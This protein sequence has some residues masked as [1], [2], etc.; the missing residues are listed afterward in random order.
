MKVSNILTEAVQAMPSIWV[1]YDPKSPEYE[2]GDIMFQAT[3]EELV[4][5]AKGMQEDP[6]GANIKFYAD[7]ESAR[8]DAETRM[9]DQHIM[10]Q[11]PDE[12]PYAAYP[13][14]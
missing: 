13:K 8:R 10:Q 14:W 7:E 3:P 12:D 2:L 11:A 9:Q 1:V 4:L 5:W 6:R